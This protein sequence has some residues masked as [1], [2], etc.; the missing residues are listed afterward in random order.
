MKMKVGA[1][2]PPNVVVELA[3]GMILSAINKAQGE[4]EPPSN[5]HLIVTLPANGKDYYVQVVAQPR[6]LDV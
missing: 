1:K 3:S 6:S 4:K 5:I 2:L